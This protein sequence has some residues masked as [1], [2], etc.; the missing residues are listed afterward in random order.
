MYIFP[1]LHLQL[2]FSFLYFAFENIAFPSDV[3]FFT[4]KREVHS[5]FV[6]AYA[7]FTRKKSATR[8]IFS[9]PA[10]AYWRDGLRSG[11][12]RAGAGDPSHARVGIT[13]EFVRWI[14]V[15]GRERYSQAQT[16]L[17]PVQITTDLDEHS[18]RPSS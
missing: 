5:S 7:S 8:T 4:P 13:R 11:S 17:L 3:S 10:L 2:S 14:V 15:P 6:A 12:A 18:G 9:T 16:Y 1:P